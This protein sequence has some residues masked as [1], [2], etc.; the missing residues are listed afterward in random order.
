MSLF[1]VRADGSDIAVAAPTMQ[2]A[3][4]AA[5][6]R[7]L[8]ENAGDEEVDREWAGGLIEQVVNVNADTVLLV[9]R[10]S[11]MLFS[12]DGISDWRPMPEGRA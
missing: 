7:I 5:I 3:I 12:D 1:L 8:E 4:D 11:W 9:D 6:E 2:M 10:K